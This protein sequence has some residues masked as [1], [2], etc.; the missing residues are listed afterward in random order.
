MAHNKFEALQK[1]PLFDLEEML[2]NRWGR[3]ATQVHKEFWVD[4]KL[5]EIEA[6]RAIS[7]EIIKLDVLEASSNK[8]S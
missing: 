1:E 3:W 6:K 7:A 5:S 8:A 2:A 4:L